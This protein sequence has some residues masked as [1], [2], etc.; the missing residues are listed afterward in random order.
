MPAGGYSGSFH[1]MK[2]LLLYSPALLLAGAAACGRRTAFTQP[3]VA[4]IARLQP[5]IA[6]ETVGED[7]DDPA[8]WVHPSIR[9]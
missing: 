9:R 5:A 3:P 6:T 1:S 2:L 4:D 7:A 8:I